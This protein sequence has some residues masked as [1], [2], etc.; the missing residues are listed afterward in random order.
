VHVAL[1]TCAV[2]PEYVFGGQSVHSAEP[3]AALNFPEMHAAQ[4]TAFE[5]VK[6]RLHRHMLELLLP[7][8]ETAFA[9]QEMQ[10]VFDVAAVTVEY[11]F[12]RQS[13]H[14]TGPVIALCL[15]AWHALQ[16]RPSWPFTCE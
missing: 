6:P 4:P 7:T 9:V 3:V 2:R 11:E 1:E 12:S 13:V 16:G 8:I 15:P 10:V 5:P 14:G